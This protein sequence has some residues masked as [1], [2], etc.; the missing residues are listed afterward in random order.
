MKHI[1][2]LANTHIWRYFKILIGSL[3]AGL[4]YSTFIIPAKLLASGLSGIAVIV[5]YLIDLPIGLQLIVYNIPIVYLAYRVFGKLYAIDTIIGTVMLSIAIDATSFIGNYHI[6]EDPILNS[7]FGGVLVGIGC[8]IVFRANSNGGGFD[9]LGAVIKKYYSLDLG[10]VVFGFNLIII[11]VGIVLFNVSIGLYTLINMYIVGEITNKVVAG[12]NRK[13]LIIIV[14]PFAELMAGSIMQYLG[15]GVT[16]MHGEGAYSRKDRK[17]IFV[18]VSLTQ[19][20]KIKL[21]A[22]AIDPTA[23]MIITDTSEVT[24]HGFTIKNPKE[25]T[26]KKT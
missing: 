24:G 6:V 25:I 5:Y 11:L 21:I 15:R 9:V 22:S 26:I 4:G 8:G 14:S 16:F 20:S 17:V 23:F 2:E 7:V 13:K 10:T 12:F 18:V 19:V 1:S 3:I